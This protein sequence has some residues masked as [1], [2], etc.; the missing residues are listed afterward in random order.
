[1]AP[2]SSKNVSSEVELDVTEV[3]AAELLEEVWW[4]A[5]G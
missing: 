2:L 4:L 3:T 1:V 5:P